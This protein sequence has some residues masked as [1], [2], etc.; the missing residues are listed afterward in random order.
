MSTGRYTEIGI[1]QVIARIK[2]QLRLVNTTEWDDYFEVVI[3][4]G[5]R[6]LRPLSMYK[7]Q[8]CK[9]E[10]VD[11]KGKLPAG[12]YQLLGIRYDLPVVGGEESA[13]CVTALYVDKKFLSD[14]GCDT[15]T[16]TIYDYNMGFQIVGQYV[17]WN[18]DISDTTMTLAYYGFNLDE[19]GRI[20]IYEDY[21]RALMS[22]ACYQYT[23]SWPDK[24]PVS[25]RAE[26]NAQWVNQRAMLRGEDVAFHFTID[27]REVGNV[28]RALAIG[29]GVNY[30]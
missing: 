4:E 7:K 16:G 11:R 5:L 15:A 2:M 24:Y 9:L 3:E 27:K 20:V 10:I 28:F 8:Q 1:D 26:Y 30:L 13:N 25:L 29:Q 23:M 19:N 12:F 22:Y 21:E 6:S 18:T 14:C 17:H